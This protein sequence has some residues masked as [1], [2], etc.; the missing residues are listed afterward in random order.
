MTQRRFLSHVPAVK[1]SR[2]YTFGGTWLAGETVT[3]TI[4][5]IDLVLTLGTAPT[6]TLVA[7]N[8]YQAYLNGTLTS[9]WSVTPGV[10]GSGNTGGGYSMPQFYELVPTNPSAGVLTLEG[11]TAGK[12]VT[13]SLAT[14]SASGTITPGTLISATGPND[15]DA[16]DNF[17]DNGELAAADDLVLDFGTTTQ[18]DAKYGLDQSAIQLTSITKMKACTGNVGLPE[19][20]R[21]DTATGRS[22]GEYRTKRL[23]TGSGGITTIRKQDPP[24]Y[25]TVEEIP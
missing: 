18:S 10:T 6:G 17:D 20:N 1:Q 23:T 19:Q 22:Y 12:P 14:N 8:V 13:I 25:F 5:N 16:A 4:D 24:F 3:L 21:D 7:T 11:R 15:L 2:S 9:G